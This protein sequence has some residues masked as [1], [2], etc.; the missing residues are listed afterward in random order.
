[1]YSGIRKNQIAFLRCPDDGHEL[2]V[3]KADV[4]A[5][6]AIVQGSLACVRCD[7]CF[8]VRDGIIIMRNDASVH[9]ESRNEELQ[10]DQ[11]ARQAEF[12]WEEDSASA[13]EIDSTLAALDPL[14]QMSVLEL[15]CGCGR[16]T[17]RLARRA[18]NV[19]AVDFSIGSLRRLAARLRPQDPVALV[20][21][22]VTQFK[23]APGAFDRALSTLTSNLPTAEHRSAL[24]RLAASA[25]GAEGRFVFSAHYLGLRERLHGEQKA[26]H[27]PG[28]G[29]YR[30]LFGFRE[31]RTETLFH[32][33]DVRCRRIQVLVPLL[34]R[35][36]SL[37]RV[38]S[39]IG[40]HV[41]GLNRFAGLLLVTA[42][43]PRAHS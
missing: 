38:L 40:E 1:M 14:E 41:P 19:I 10:R 16:Y 8:E 43:R 29:I 5:A 12:A 30:Y 3:A 6:G 21:A 13:S 39:R 42:R 34:G 17:H 35:L 26:G 9:T 27:Y 7:R 24:N 36:K 28:S 2:A 25:L 15:G 22:D 37:A 20:C 4:D 23:V 33:D 31:V 11:D 18:E 32:F